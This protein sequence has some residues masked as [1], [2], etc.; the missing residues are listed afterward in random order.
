M[1]LR[2]SC[3]V[4]NCFIKPSGRKGTELCGV[5]I[6]DLLPLLSAAHAHTH[7]HT[8]TNRNTNMFSSGGLF[9]YSAFSL[10]ITQ[11]HLGLGEQR[12]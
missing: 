6:T 5:M 10:Q 12:D 7:T 11:E 4:S 3:T 9:N 8:L 1:K 2:T